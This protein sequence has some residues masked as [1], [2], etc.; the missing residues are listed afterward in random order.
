MSGTNHFLLTE[1]LF[2]RC[3]GL[4]MPATRPMDNMK[5]DLDRPQEDEFALCM[6]GAEF[7]Y[8]N[9]AFPNNSPNTDDHLDLEAVTPASRVRW[10]RVFYG[11]L[12]KVA[13]KTG[14]RLVLKSPPHTA[15]IKTLKAM[16]PDALF[17]HIVRNPYVVFPSTIN[18]W[19]T[20]HKTQALQ[21][22]T[23]VE[24]YE[25][26][27]N[28]FVHMYDK[29]EAGKASLSPGQFYE[30]TYEDLIKDPLGEMKKIYDHF[31]LGG[32]A[33][34]LPRLHEYLAANKSYETNKY[35]LSKA[36]RAMVAQRW[37]KVIR[38]YGY[39]AP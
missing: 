15:R 17:I 2:K 27:L 9:I 21:T 37:D 16:F 20:L 39:A 32:F 19:Q 33:A 34:T 1:R 36:E 38:R 28:T 13:Y 12:Q 22:P 26:V 5:L 14:K 25:R 31:G 35:K 10:M 30:L 8:L 4:L 7:P 29:L 24:L 18:L 23:D 3:L 11:F 6:L